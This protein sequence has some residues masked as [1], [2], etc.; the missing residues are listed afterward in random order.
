MRKKVTLVLA[1]MGLAAAL[2][3]CTK[4]E[5]G[6]ITDHNCSGGGG[7]YVPDFCAKYTSGNF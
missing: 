4:Y 2:S 7:I 5:N 1:A 3:A 6:F